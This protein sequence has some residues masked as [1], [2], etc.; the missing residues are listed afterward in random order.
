MDGLLHM[1]L[2]RN[3]SKTVISKYQLKPNYYFTLSSYTS[4]L[5]KSILRSET[6]IQRQTELRNIKKSSVTKLLS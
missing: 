2:I 6:N 4:L 5:S 1:F 3:W